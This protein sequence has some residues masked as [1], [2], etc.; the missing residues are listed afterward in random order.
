MKTELIEIK[1][2]NTGTGLLID[3]DGYMYLNESDAKT[4][5]E[6][7]GD[8]DHWKCPFPFVVHAVFQKYGLKNA[9]GRIYPE[10]VLRKQVELYQQKINEH[11]ALG[12]CYPLNAQVLTENGWVK[13]ADI[14][15][16]DNVLTLNTETNKTE[17]NKVVR[18]IEKKHTGDMIRIVG[19]GINELVTPDHGYPIYSRKTNKFVEYQTAKQIMAHMQSYQEDLYIPNNISNTMLGITLSNKYIN[20]M[21]VSYDDM[22]GCIEVP[23][24]TFYVQVNGFKHW[25]KN[26]NHPAESVIDLGRIS[27]NITELHWEGRTLVGTMELNVSQGFVKQGICSTFGDT[28]A[29]LL[30]NGYKI[31]V[32]SRGVGSVNKKLDQYIVGDDFELICWDIVSDPSTPNAWIGGKDEIQQYVESKSQTKSLLSDKLNKIKNII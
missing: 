25:S 12:E 2:N 4:I 20:C 16:G 29:N 18:K 32:S 19:R 21:S 6:S 31:G 13:M 26:C 14:K 5:K 7:F 1:K 9:N 24:H 8:D 3:N 30:L 22:V 27:H 23:N 11:R 15:E 17:F 28:V 10:H